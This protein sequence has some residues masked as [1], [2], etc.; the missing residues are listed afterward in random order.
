MPTYLVQYR[1]PADGRW[2]NC[3]GFSH[4]VDAMARFEAAKAETGGQWRLVKNGEVI[5]Y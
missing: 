5:A 2:T 3:Y 1:I 4:H